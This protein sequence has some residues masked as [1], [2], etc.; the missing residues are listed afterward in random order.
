[1]YQGSHLLHVCK[2]NLNS[3]MGTFV[4]D[5]ADSYLASKE[6]ETSR[7]DFQGIKAENSHRMVFDFM[8]LWAASCQ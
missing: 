7:K 4:N 5:L 1:M 8:I 6:W 2:R 3:G